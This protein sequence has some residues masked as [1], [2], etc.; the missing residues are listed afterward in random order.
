MTRGILLFAFNNGTTDYFKMAVATANRAYRFLNLQT[1]VVTDSNTVIEDY[2]HNFEN[3]IIVDS[4]NT[5]RNVNKEIWINKGRFQAYDLSPYDETLLLDT[6]YLINSDMLLKPFELY[7][8]FMC[9][10][11]TEFLMKPNEG[12]EKISKYSFNTL[13]ATVVYFKKTKKTKLIFDTMK[14]VQENYQH[15][16]N[17]YNPI[18]GFFRNDYALTFALRIVN[19]QTEDISNYIPWAL[20]HADKDV[21]LISNDNQSCVTSYNVFLNQSTSRGL[22]KQFITIKDKDVHMINK[23]NFMEIA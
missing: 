20:T 23:E 1:T 8:D 2:H 14:M 9:H 7:D 22:K 17:I 12:Q 3:I 19:G 5:N 11:T 15:Y 21:T 16:I 6:D 10:N 13:W 4:D 18:V